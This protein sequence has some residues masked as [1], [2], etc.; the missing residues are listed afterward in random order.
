MTWS[1]FPVIARS[2]CDEAIHLAPCVNLDCFA[3]LAMTHSDTSF[4]QRF[5]GRLGNN[6]P[7]S[8]SPQLRI[9][10]VAQPVAEQIDRQDQGGERD[11]GKG[12]DPPF[13]GEQIV[14]ADPD[15]GSER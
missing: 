4:H 12:D 6:S 14:V 15:Q 1:C 11:P 2:P 3:A 7:S 10:G 9:E 5:Y 13:A 8:S